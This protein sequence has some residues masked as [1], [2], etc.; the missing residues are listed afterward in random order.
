MAIMLLML[1]TLAL[2]EVYF[3][4]KAA[5]VFGFN[6]TKEENDL[7]HKDFMWV[8][9]VSIL[10]VL[11]HY[12][13]SWWLLGVVFYWI[14]FDLAVNLLW[15]KKPWWYLGTTSS[16]DGWFSP[17]KNIVIKIVLLIISLILAL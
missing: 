11:Y 17:T 2:A 12:H 3:D 8:R 15:L 6:R 9:G 14:V 7:I 5:G 1:F 13:I 16:T 10:C 4:S